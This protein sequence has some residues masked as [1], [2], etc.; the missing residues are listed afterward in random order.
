MA[1]NY[2]TFMFFQVA[3]FGVIALELYTAVEPFLF[4]EPLMQSIWPLQA[5]CSR[6]WRHCSRGS[7]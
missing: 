2:S 6:S 4:G 1:V 3:L 5:Q 7:T